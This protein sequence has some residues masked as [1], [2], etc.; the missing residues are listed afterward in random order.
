MDSNIRPY[1]NNSWIIEQ[2]NTSRRLGYLEHSGGAFII[3]ADA[4]TPL[5]GVRT[6]P[7]LSK[8]DAM[9]TI[10]DKLGGTCLLGV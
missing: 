6:G 3:V 8:E 7:W 4:G 5:E 1:S 2:K 10:G 9:A